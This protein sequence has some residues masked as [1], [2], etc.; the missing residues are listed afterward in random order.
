MIG[1]DVL[2]TV[3]PSVITATL[4]QRTGRATCDGNRQPR[5]NSHSVDVNPTTNKANVA[6]EAG[7]NVLDID[8]STSVTT[9]ISTQG[10]SPDAIRYQIPSITRSMP[11]T[12]TMEQSP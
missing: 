4:G 5:R 2:Y 11:L 8:R 7:Q 12:R 9:V 3:Q 6:N 1:V 10:L